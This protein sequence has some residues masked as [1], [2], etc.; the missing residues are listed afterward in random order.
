MKKKKKAKLSPWRTG[1]LSWNENPKVKEW[2]MDV[3]RRYKRKTVPLWKWRKGLPELVRSAEKW[4]DRLYS[5]ARNGAYV[6]VMQCSMDPQGRIRS[7]MVGARRCTNRGPDGQLRIFGEVRMMAHASVTLFLPSMVKH[8]QL[9]RARDE[10]MR[11]KKKA[12]R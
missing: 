7:V 1:G 6:S 4:I 2:D 3:L 9:R 5:Q 12:A 10:R 8:A 11:K